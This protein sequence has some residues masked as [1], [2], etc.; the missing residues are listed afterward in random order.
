VH[1][2]HHRCGGYGLKNVAKPHRHDDRNADRDDFVGGVKDGKTRHGDDEQR[3]ASQSTGTRSGW[4]HD[5]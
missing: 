3:D 1:W 4:R 2:Q 5:H